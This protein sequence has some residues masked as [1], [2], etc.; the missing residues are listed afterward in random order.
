M[1]LSNYTPHYTVDDYARWEGDWELW[2]GYPI[3]MNP[4][5]G[6][7]HQ[8][9]S[10]RI[11]RHLSEALERAGCRQCVAV[12]EVDW[13]ADE[14]TIL[15]PDISV[16]CEHPVQAF[17]TN[18]P[19]LVV[20]VLSDSTRQR[21]LLYKREMYE[22]LG[23]AVYM[24]ADPENSAITVLKRK[25]GVYQAGDTSTLTLHTECEISLDLTELFVAL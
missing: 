16:V 15:R 13:R 21:D 17:L 19:S 23:V 22:K 7:A 5:P 20:E 24:I 2:S 8:I 25:K 4:S 9:L 11:Y 12:P 1:A 18:V 6:M 14:D 3:A 10:G